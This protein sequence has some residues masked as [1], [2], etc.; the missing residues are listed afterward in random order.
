MGGS[1]ADT[2]SPQDKLGGSGVTSTQR[3]PKPASPG[4]L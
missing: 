3:L 2:P 1:L 4:L